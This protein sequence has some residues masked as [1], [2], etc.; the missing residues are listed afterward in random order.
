MASWVDSPKP[1]DAPP[2]GSG[3]PRDD[4][5]TS[6][7]PHCWCG[8]PLIPKLA[9]AGVTRASLRVECPVHGYANFCVDHVFPDGNPETVYRSTSLKW[10]LQYAADLRDIYSKGGGQWHVFVHDEDDGERGSLSEDDL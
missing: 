4:Y 6:G 1:D 5:G 7:D 2:P 10:A 8:R 9:K 3:E